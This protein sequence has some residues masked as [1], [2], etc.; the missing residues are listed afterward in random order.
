MAIS[1][2]YQT[3]LN[4]SAWKEKR[5]KVLTRAKFKCEKC[6]K[7]QAWQIHHLTY[8]RIYDE[9]LSDLQAVCGQCH[10]KIHGIKPEKKRRKTKLWK[11]FKRVYQKVIS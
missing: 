2:E 10:M 11:R 6:K 7:R 3:Y 8:E 4:S 9:E 5:L 1:Q